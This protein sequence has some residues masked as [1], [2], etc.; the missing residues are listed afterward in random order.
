[1]LYFCKRS[2]DYMKQISME[3]L[4]AYSLSFWTIV[5]IFVSLNAILFSV[6]ISMAAT[7]LKVQYIPDDAFY[8]LTLSRNYSILGLWTF[9]SGVSVTSGF[10]PLFA[11]LL[12]GA[13]SLL[14]P[15]TNSF[16]NYGILISLLFSLGTITIIWFWGYKHKN[17]VFLMFLS[18]VISSQTFVYNT[19]SITEWSLAL[20]F[21]SLYCGW[22]F[23]KYEDSN[24]KFVDFLILFTLGFFGSVA[25][26]DFGLFP[27][28]IVI[29]TLFLPLF[30]IPSKKS[31]RYAITG[32]AG[33]ITGVL[34]VFVHNYIFT[35]E[36]FQSSAKM[37][38]YW[39]QFGTPNP[40]TI[41]FLFIR[42]IGLTSLLLLVIP[43]AFILILK[44]VNKIAGHSSTYI[45][46]LGLRPK[47][48]ISSIPLN[49]LANDRKR[50]LLIMSIS[51]GICILGY[52][53]IYSGNAD[54]QPWYTANLTVPV[55]M[56]IFGISE[57]TT[58]T[59]R[60]SIKFLYLLLFLTALIIN[61]VTLYPINSLK[62]PW[63]HQ[64]FMY[65]AGIYLKENPT[66]CK[67]G[68]WNAG[69]IGYY[70]GG[71]VVNLDGLVNNDIYDYVVNNDLPAYLSS[72]DICYVVDFENIITN[73]L[74]HMRGGY[75]DVR[76]LASLKPQK[77]FDRGEY[78][79]RCLTLYRIDSVNGS[80]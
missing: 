24:I 27:F 14:Q 1:M 47:H 69:I 44:V 71:H 32:L 73:E 2:I 7:N 46:S 40:Y 63:P 11:Y 9:D 65:K 25:R 76:F 33:A 28:S 3:K 72:R 34:V 61:I 8:Y 29:S 58:I 79:W 52:A 64:Q 53:F 5:I 17:V 41:P 38:A 30:N 39:A 12:S 48:S 10:H 21:T 35:N 49:T 45:R 57:Y 59:L 15:N 70:E 66:R 62:A 16:V 31:L 56:L 74:A 60:E 50:G 36:I 75:D 26:S 4:K 23:S 42:V 67:T 13:Y 43:T 51:A 6:K 78:S 80:D 37:K 68:A 55:L 18:L 22:Y 20:F 54:I 19:V 77:V